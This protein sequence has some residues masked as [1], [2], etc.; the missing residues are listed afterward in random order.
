MPA[1]PESKPPS[2]AAG[3]PWSSA[4]SEK[5]KDDRLCMPG[6]CVNLFLGFCM[7]S[8]KPPEGVDEKT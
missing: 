2:A 5:V 8:L 7:S 4:S 6:G 1:S 3:P